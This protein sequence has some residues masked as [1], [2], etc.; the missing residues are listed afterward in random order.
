MAPWG[1]HQFHEYFAPRLLPGVETLAPDHYCRTVSIDGAVGWI[2]VRPLP[3]QSVVE[4]N[5][6]ES[7]I[8]HAFTL[9]HRVRK[10]F[11]LDADPT[12]ISR[13]LAADPLLL[14]LV[15]A[16]PG[17]RLPCAFDP[18]EQAVRAVIGQQVTVK[19]AVTITRRLVERH[20]PTWL[21]AQ[22]AGPATLFKLFPS[23]QIIASA[24][25][26]SIGMPARRVATLQRLA[27]AVANGA[28]DLRIDDGPGALIR[29]LCEL[30]GIGPW[31]AEYIALRGFGEPDAFRLP[32]LG[33][34]KPHC[35][36]PMASLPRNC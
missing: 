5:I 32:I 16:E 15:T 27:S 14:P 18:S 8:D 35:G 22:G 9:T 12:A 34:L 13:H 25:L 26:D 19:A 21:C 23:P 24:T 11:D 20:G 29:R 3:G 33:C 10:M 17:L 6:S 30:P 7:L 28:F 31:T 4:L 1:W 2:S 36:A